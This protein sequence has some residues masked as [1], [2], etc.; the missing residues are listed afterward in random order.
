M[1]T[2]YELTLSEKVLLS[3]SVMWDISRS[4]SE[5]HLNSKKLKRGYNDHVEFTEIDPFTGQ[6]RTI[7]R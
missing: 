6:I 5:K 4:K 3:S 2:L 7:R 1:N